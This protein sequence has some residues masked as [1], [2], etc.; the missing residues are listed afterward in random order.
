M[1]LLV[2]WRPRGSLEEPRMAQAIPRVMQ[3]RLV[4][5]ERPPPWA[6]CGTCQAHGVRA[7]GEG[8]WGWGD[9]Q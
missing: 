9:S 8:Q 5:E 2:C 7:D 1:V 4:G 3:G 6:A